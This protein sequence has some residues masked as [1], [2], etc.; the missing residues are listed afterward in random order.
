MGKVSMRSLLLLVFA[1]VAFTALYA[2]E[3][4]DLSSADVA[5]PLQTE[6]KSAQVSA[7][8]HDAADIGEGT[9]GFGGALMTS[10]SFTMMAANTGMGEEEELGEGEGTGGLGGAL[11]TSGSFTMMAANTGM[12]L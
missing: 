9:G 11:M 8:T 3:L 2:D 1:F 7:P 5:P 12:R 4:K 10:G 6:A